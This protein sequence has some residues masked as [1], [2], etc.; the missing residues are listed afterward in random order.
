M[1]NQAD[2][3]RDRELD[4]LV[5]EFLRSRRG[6]WRI[7]RIG[8]RNHADVQDHRDW[9]S[10]APHCKLTFM[11]LLLCLKDRARSLRLEPPD[12]P[13][14]EGLSRMSYVISD[15]SHDLVPPP[16][17]TLPGISQEFRRLAGLSSWMRRLGIAVRALARRIDDRQE[18]A[19]TG[20]FRI[21]CG[22]DGCDVTV[23]IEPTSKGDRLIVSISDVAPTLSVASDDILRRLMATRRR[24]QKNSARVS[25]GS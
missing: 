13:D 21:T 24:I 6:A 12:D 11:V 3:S 20:T 18:G 8:G 4:A 19:D 7:R 10:W 2:P 17:H 22:E 1:S 14:G 16:R 15:A 23:R 25:K 5:E 9:W